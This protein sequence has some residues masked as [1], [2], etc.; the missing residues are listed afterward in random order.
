MGNK[1]ILLPGLNSQNV[2]NEHVSLSSL[3]SFLRWDGA[4]HDRDA[5][6]HPQ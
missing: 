1:P 4:S 5:S 3:L 2:L 6:K